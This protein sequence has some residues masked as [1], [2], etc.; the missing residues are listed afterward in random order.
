M[1]L[2]GLIRPSIAGNAQLIVSKYSQIFLYFRKKMVNCF[3]ERVS[4]YVKV[5]VNDN[6]KNKSLYYTIVDIIFI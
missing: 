3:G 6:G 4:V 1:S 2:G 5:N